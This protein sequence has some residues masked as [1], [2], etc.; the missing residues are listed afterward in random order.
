MK[1]SSSSYLT[2][3][4]LAGSVAATLA[5]CDEP[6]LP[7]PKPV[8]ASTVG[9]ATVRIVNAAPGTTGTSFTIDALTAGATLPYLAT[10][11]VPNILAGQRLLL[12]SEPTNIPATPTAAIAAGVAPLTVARPLA[13]RSSFSGNTSY[14]VFLTD[15]PTRAYVYPVT[16]TS[17]QG[18]I[19]SVTLTDNLTSTANRAR[20][21]FINLSPSFTSGADSLGLY[22]TV[23]NRFQY[24]P[25]GRTYRST[26]YTVPNSNPARTTNFATFNE[27]TPGA[28]TFDVRRGLVGG[29]N[30][31]K[32]EFTPQALTLEAGKSYT[33]YTS[34]LRG[35]T[36]TPLAISVVNH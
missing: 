16:A 24:R 1:F 22:N 25:I 21:R 5:S 18:G 11:T 13:L 30:N 10:T 4:A 14:T 23:T 32:V 33:I 17:D 19:R 3:L 6:T 29:T 31:L 9:T 8:T 27:V 15:Q 34:G 28:Y 26:S 12:F 20:I 2:K 36:T 35:S 7:E